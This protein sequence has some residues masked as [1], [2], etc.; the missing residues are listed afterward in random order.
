MSWSEYYE[1][2]YDRWKAAER[3]A[4]FWKKECHKLQERCDTLTQENEELKERLTKLAIAPGS[5]ER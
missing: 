4:E 2:D 1:D 3:S 5:A